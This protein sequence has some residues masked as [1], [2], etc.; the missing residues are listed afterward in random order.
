MT[1]DLPV[2]LLKKGCVCF[3]VGTFAVTEQGE[4]KLIKQGEGETS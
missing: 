3:R 1:S 4:G 2:K